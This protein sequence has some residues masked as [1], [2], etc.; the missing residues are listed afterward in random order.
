MPTPSMT[1]SSKS[2]YKGIST[3]CEKFGVKLRPEFGK[4]IADRNLV[5]KVDFDLGKA[6]ESDE[7]L[8]LSA[9]A[10]QLVGDYQRAL[11]ERL[12]NE[13]AARATT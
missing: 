13:A 6:A 10:S 4:F 1:L 3:Y 7:P 5:G 9:Y 2:P 8:D 11:K 12:D